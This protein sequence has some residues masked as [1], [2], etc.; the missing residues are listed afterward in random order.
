MNTAFSSKIP[1]VA[2]GPVAAADPLW[3]PNLG[4]LR[5]VAVFGPLPQAVSA[6][7]LTMPANAGKSIDDLMLGKK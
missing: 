3:P 1:D 7:A 6:H 4:T 2:L 5:T